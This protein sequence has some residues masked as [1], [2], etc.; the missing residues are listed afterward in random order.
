MLFIVDVL[1]V[2]YVVEVF[3]GLI[4]IVVDIV[5]DFYYCVCGVIEMVCVQLGI[6]VEMLGVVFKF[7]VMLGV[8]Q[9][10][11]L[12]LGQYMWDVLCDYGLIDVQIDVLVL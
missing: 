12:C 4:Y 7:F 5:V 2:L 9:V 10:S 3:S 11:V 8:V 1:V 6:D